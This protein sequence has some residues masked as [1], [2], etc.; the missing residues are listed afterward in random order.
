MNNYLFKNIPIRS[1]RNLERDFF[2]KEVEGKEKK[3]RKRRRKKEG[4]RK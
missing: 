2:P 1:G 3:E 4:K